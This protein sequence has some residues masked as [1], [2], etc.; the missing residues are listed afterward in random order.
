MKNSCFFFPILLAVA[1][2][3]HAEDAFLKDCLDRLDDANSKVKSIVA[4]LAFETVTMGQKQVVEGS[5]RYLNADKEYASTELRQPGMKVLAVQRGD[6]LYN[7]F[8]NTAWT[9][10]KIEPGS[11][12]MNPILQL[13]AYFRKE[14]LTFQEEKNG[15]R[16]YSATISKG[17]E[18][19]KVRLSI[20]ASNRRLESI[21]TLG[22][23]GETVTISEFYYSA[24]QG[25]DFPYKTAI[26]T[27]GE[28]PISSSQE[29][30]NI[31][32]NASLPKSWFVPN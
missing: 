22:D 26:R 12:G 20:N 4:E 11:G 31:T 15:V 21:Q 30:R 6:S 9:A 14:S 3:A 28:A 16:I 32:L 8:G 1:C 5:L 19:V 27:V 13:A 2:V 10:T 25:V 7:R 17:G 29:Y 24:I 18:Q 23:S